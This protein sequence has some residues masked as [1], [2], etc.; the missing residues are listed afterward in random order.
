[1][2][3]GRLAMLGLIALVATSCI[4]GLDILEV[5]NVGTGGL[6]KAAP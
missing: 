2:W 4:S 5:I 3:N 6:L 1:M